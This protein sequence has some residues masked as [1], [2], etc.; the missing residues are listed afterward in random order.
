MEPAAESVRHR[1]S[2]DLAGTA[3][4]HATP[5]SR[6]QVRAQVGKA[7]DDPG[8]PR[9]EAREPVAQSESERDDSR[10]AIPV[11]GANTIPANAARPDT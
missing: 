11:L 9:P 2:A 6:T 3:T 8:A 4:T 7:V 1:C 5:S 10:H